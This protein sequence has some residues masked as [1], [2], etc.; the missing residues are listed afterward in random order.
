MIISS[1]GQT[2]SAY[3]ITLKLPETYTIT[4]KLPDHEISFLHSRL[5]II[6]TLTPADSIPITDEYPLSSHSVT[7]IGL[8]T[9]ACG[10]QLFYQDCSA[11]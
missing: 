3:T 2:T 4:L 6:S 8:S 9:G 7:F 1:A 5:V 10:V 11:K